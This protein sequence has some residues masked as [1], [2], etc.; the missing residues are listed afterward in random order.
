MIINSRSG[1]SLNQD[2]QS[3]TGQLKQTLQQAGWRIEA[4]ILAPE[5]LK[6]GLHEAMAD[7]NTDCV[8]V[9]GGDGT[10]KTAAELSLKQNKPIGIIP[11]GT[12]NR[13]ARDLQLPVAPVEAAQALSTGKLVRVDCAYAN[14][15]LFLCNC[16]LG[17][18]PRLATGRQ[19]LRG[20]SFR[21]RLVGYTTLLSRIAAARRKLT[22]IID[23][24]K[25]TKKRVRALSVVVSNNSYKNDPDLFLKRSALDTGLLGVYLSKHRNGLGLFAA[26]FKA[27]LGLWHGDKA[28]DHMTAK[29]V[30]IDSSK[31]Y[32]LASLDGEVKLLATPARF[33]IIQ[34]SLSVIVPKE[35]S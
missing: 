8:I 26:Y 29:T 13:M 17:L 4:Q 11:L 30:Q 22:F 18:P 7:P 3:L 1:T 35:F 21:Q 15:E 12:L 2:V 14:D 28:I 33:K 25:H 27:C 19:R 23:D 24:H 16:L 20:K 10:V 6:S 5:D 32:L 31:R 34:K 9:G